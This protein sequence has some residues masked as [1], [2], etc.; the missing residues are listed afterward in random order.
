MYLWYFGNGHMASSLLARNFRCPGLETRAVWRAFS[1]IAW[2][3]AQMAALW[4]AISKVFVRPLVKWHVKSKAM[5][6]LSALDDHI[7][8][9]IGLPRSEIEALA[10]DYAK[11]YVENGGE[12]GRW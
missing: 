12:G 6:K 9:D 11:Q 2:G 8:Q 7:L 5:K 10:E 3:G 4:T 1:A